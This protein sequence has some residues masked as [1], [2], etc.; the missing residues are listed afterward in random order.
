[1]QTDAEIAGIIL[2]RVVQNVYANLAMNHKLVVVAIDEYLITPKWQIERGCTWLQK[3]QGSSNM[4]EALRR[5][6]GSSD[7]PPQV[8][9]RYERLK[10]DFD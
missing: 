5:Y 8:W 4:T 2:N 7:Y 6:N 1:M 10:K 9:E 3:K